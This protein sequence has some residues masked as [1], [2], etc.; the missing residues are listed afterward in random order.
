MSFHTERHV[1]QS[2]KQRKCDWCWEVIAKG[3]PYVSVFGVFEG[4][5]YKSKYHPEC[6]NAVYRWVEANRAWGEP[7][8]QDRMNRGGIQPHGEE[9]K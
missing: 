7:L 2:R 8:C 5:V 9:E 1:K 4:D 6:N 3:G